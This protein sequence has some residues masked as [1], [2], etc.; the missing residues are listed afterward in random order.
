MSKIRHFLAKNPTGIDGF[1]VLSDGGLPRGRATVVSGPAGSGKTIFGLEFLYRGVTRYKE[2]GVFVTFEEPKREIIRETDGFGWDL[3]GLEKRGQIAFVDASGMVQEQVEIG[4]YDFGALIARI[5]YAVEKAGAKRVV[6]DSVSALFLRYKEQATV[7]RELFRMVETLRRLGVT[8]IITAERVRDED[9]ASR[10]GVEDFV[11]DSVVFLY[12]TPVGRDRERQIEIV[13]LRGGAH[14]TGR[15]A[16]LIDATGLVV[17]P[18]GGYEFAPESPTARVSTGVAGIDAMTAGGLYRGSTTLLLGPSGSGRSVLGLHFLNEGRRR[19]ERGLLLS[20]E[21]GR[22]QLFADA[23]SFNWDFKAAEKRGQLDIL[24]W[25][26]EAMPLEY[27]FQ[28]LKEIIAER[29]PKRVVIDS[30]TPLV[31]SNGEQRFRRFFVSL[32]VFLKTAGCTTLITYTTGQKIAEAVAAESDMAM[33]ADNIVAM[34]LTDH[35]AETA[36]EILVVKSRASAHDEAVRRY[37]ISAKGLNV[38]G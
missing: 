16:M 13:K 21:E 31:R 11:A 14:Q 22:A 4:D 3:G 23:G 27:Y 12:N 17:F 19:R 34:R 29:R 15:H 32:N 7:R 5:R 24:A 10:F 35:G 25:Q 6:I 9:A 1:D 26:P 20:F 33:V 38:L 37:A 2:P 30:L 8:S 28:R 36:H 18:G